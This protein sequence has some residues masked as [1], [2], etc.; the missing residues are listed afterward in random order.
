M[1]IKE[2]YEVKISWCLQNFQCGDGG[3]SPWK[4]S[5]NWYSI[6]ISEGECKTFNLK[7]L[8]FYGFYFFNWSSFIGLLGHFSNHK[9]QSC[10]WVC[11][12]VCQCFGESCSIILARC[13]EVSVVCFPGNNGKYFKWF[14]K[15]LWH[16]YFQYCHLK[17]IRIEECLIWNQSD[18]L[19]VP[20]RCTGSTFF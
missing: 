11:R 18:S 12:S 15:C 13:I 9:W 3:W 4:N 7:W 17:G 6:W 8:M 20:V 1:A 16:V 19:L 5:L 10:N 14:M 2:P